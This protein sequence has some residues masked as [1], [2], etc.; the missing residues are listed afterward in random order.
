VVLSPPLE[1][2]VE[3]AKRR[4]SKP[5]DGSDWDDVLMLDTAEESESESRLLRLDTATTCFTSCS[6]KTTRS[7]SAADSA[8]ND[9]MVAASS[10][11]VLGVVS[12]EGVLTALTWLIVGLTSRSGGGGA[13]AA[14]LMPALGLI[15]PAARPRSF[16][17][18]NT[19]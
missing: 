9:E 3:L 4:L 2:V 7:R 16:A 8:L 1:E 19:L 18:D 11:D 12:R 17:S 5:Y 6:S 15:P 10:E 14:R 13:T